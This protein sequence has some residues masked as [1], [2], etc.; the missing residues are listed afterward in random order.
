[1]KH[2]HHITPKHMGGTDDPENLIS[3]TPKDHAKA[4]QDLYEK[5]GK[6]EDYLAWKG[7]EG[8]IGKE[9][10]VKTL[11]VENGKRNGDNAYKKK[12]GFHNPDFRKSERYKKICSEN[13]KIQG[14]KHVESGHCKRIAPLGGGKN[15]GK[16]FWFNPEAGEETQAFISPG[17][18]W[19]K[20]R[21]MDRINVEYLRKNADN[22]KGT[23][24]ITNKETGETRMIPPDEQIP[25]GFTKGRIFS[26]SNLIELH[27]TSDKVHIDGIPQ[28]AIEYPHIIFN[29][30]NSRWE[31]IPKVNQKRI[32]KISHT[33][34][35]GLVWARDCYLDLMSIKGEK[36]KFGF[37]ANTVEEI[38]NVLKDWREYL[39]TLDIL[40][41]DNMKKF[42]RARY[43]NK[44]DS[45]RKNYEFLEGIRNN[46]IL[47]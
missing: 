1:M 13:G 24:W 45:L 10:I 22:V 2:K 34:Y 11:M 4:H 20:G 38:Q 47:G 39:R 44:L 46:I 15:L 3:L 12:I 37:T 32:I 30:G 29:P 19:V 9:E 43:E 40:S 28:V 7:L 35:Y 8:F 36:S 27:N 17:E 31:Y 25:E 16:N 21:N 18:N 42:R 41:S 6:M 5:Y 23:H 26:F 33:D 14:R